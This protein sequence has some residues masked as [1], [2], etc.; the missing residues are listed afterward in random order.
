VVAD[1]KEVMEDVL[2]AVIQTEEAV[3]DATTIDVMMTDATTT[4]E[5]IEVTEAIDANLREENAIMKETKVDVLIEM[6][7]TQELTD[8]I[9]IEITEITDAIT[10]DLKDA[11]TIVEIETTIEMKDV[12]ILTQ[13]VDNLA[14]EEM[15]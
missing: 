7:E 11:I 8:M 2:A 1:V 5:V 13:D 6:I 15:K 12:K 3:A 10:V 9:K 4:V 14:K